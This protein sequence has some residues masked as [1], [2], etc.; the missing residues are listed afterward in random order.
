MFI[1]T[2][3][4]SHCRRL[5]LL[6]AEMPGRLRQPGEALGQSL[7]GLLGQ[8][9]A[10]GSLCM[11]R[12]SVGGAWA[13]HPQHLPACSR[14]RRNAWRGARVAEVSATARGCA[15]RAH[16]P[17]GLYGGL[18]LLLELRLHG[19]RPAPWRPVET[20]HPDEAGR[21][22]TTSG[23]WQGSVRADGQALGCGVSPFQ[24]ERR[25]LS[26]RR[27]R[28]GGEGPWGHRRFSSQP[29][30]ATCRCAAQGK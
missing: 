9:A 22:R 28:R 4:V 1:T 12:M 23:L 18:S 2:S 17:S 20:R 13:E 30:S 24:L 5:F 8:L 14:P 15:V 3:P 26:C 19:Q 29:C 7:P 6:P 10:T 27:P 16:H 21:P 11:E 25:R